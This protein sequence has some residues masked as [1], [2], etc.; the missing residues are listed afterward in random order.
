M[1][2]IKSSSPYGERVYLEFRESQ[3]SSESVLKPE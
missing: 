2:D 1:V 3:S